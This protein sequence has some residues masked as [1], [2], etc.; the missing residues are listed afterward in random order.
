M[1]TGSMNL[2]ATIPASSFVQFFGI[3]IQGQ[4]FATYHENHGF[5]TE[6]DWDYLKSFGFAYMRFPI[7]WEQLEPVLGGDFSPTYLA[8]IET[9]LD[10]AASRN[11]KLL[12]DLHNQGTWNPDYGNGFVG[13]PG[14]GGHR[15]GVSPLTIDVFVSTWERLASRLAGHTGLLGYGLMNEPSRLMGPKNLLRGSNHFK[16]SFGAFQPWYSINSP[17]ITYREAESS[18]GLQ[19]AT[20]ITAGSGFAAVVQDVEVENGDHTVSVEIFTLEGTQQA[21]IFFDWGQST[22]V[23]ATTTKQR[24]SFTHNPGAGTYP[25]G[26][27]VES[28]VASDHV[29][30]ANAQLET[31]SSPTDYEADVWPRFAQAA[32]DT[33]REIDSN[34]YIFVN[35]DNVGV[36]STWRLSNENMVDLTDP[37]DKLVFEAHQ[38][39]DTNSAS[40]YLNSYDA[41]GVDDNTGVEL[42][43]PFKAWLQEY[44]LRGFLGEFGAPN[45]DPRWVDLEEALLEDLNDQLR[46]SLWFYGTFIAQDAGRLN[47]RPDAEGNYNEDALILDRFAQRRWTT[48]GTVRFAKAT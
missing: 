42:V 39:F 15:L 29:Y 2:E 30:I 35:G 12:I 28:A 34:A 40:T 10:A 8:S 17:A 16:D 11:L 38:Y 14:V 13:Y 46:A 45:D 31:G 21:H 6:D 1:P 24:F 19:N 7:A 26:I 27:G 33:I 47:V 25:I 43:A 20:K 18:D 9:A 3:S 22:V 44:T 48:T 37:A 23:L 41:E 32:I 5:P 4:E 36:A